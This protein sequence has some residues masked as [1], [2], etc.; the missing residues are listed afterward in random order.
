MDMCKAGIEGRS[1]GLYIGGMKAEQLKESEACDAI[2]ATY[3]LAHEGLDIPVLDTLI[4]A[5]P[6]S[7]IVQSVGRI[8]RETMGKKNNPYIIDIVDM[9][10]PFQ[11]QFFKRSKYYKSAGF[12]VIHPRD[13]EEPI[14]EF[15][16][17]DCV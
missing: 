16:E 1:F 12:H 17:E 6:K 13:S 8:L 15:H 4:M 7:D 10:G 5:S 11:Y 9:W 14:I 2:F 3:S